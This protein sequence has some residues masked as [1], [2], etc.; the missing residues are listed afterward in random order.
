MYGYQSV[1][2]LAFLTF[3]DKEVRVLT[4]PFHRPI[5]LQYAQNFQWVQSSIFP[6]EKHICPN[7]LINS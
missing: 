7:L 5:L 2:I 3:G 4:G 6:N 1:L